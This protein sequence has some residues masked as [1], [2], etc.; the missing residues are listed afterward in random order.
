M[1]KVLQKYQAEIEGIISKHAEDKK[2][3][4]KII[5]NKTKEIERMEK[6]LTDA[7]N[8]CDMEK[9]KSIK[10]NIADN[11]SEIEFYNK[12]LENNKTSASADYLELAQKYPELINDEQTKIVLENRKKL[13]AIIRN[14]TELIETTDKELKTGNDTIATIAHQPGIIDE[15]KVMIK[16]KRLWSQRNCIMAML[17]SINEIIKLS[18]GKYSYALDLKSDEN[19]W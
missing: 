7:L 2:R 12:T 3:I 6:E 15:Q 16:Q 17:R 19:F 14:L 18:E 11:E 8:N 5:D 1:N 9:Y 10:R 13:L 4:E